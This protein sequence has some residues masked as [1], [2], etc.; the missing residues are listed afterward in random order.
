LHPNI[1]QKLLCLLQGLRGGF[2]ESGSISCP[3]GSLWV[4]ARAKGI[5]KERYSKGQF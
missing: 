1:K 5:S 2:A 3:K 4:A